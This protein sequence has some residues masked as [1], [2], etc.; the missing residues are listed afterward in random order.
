M[1]CMMTKGVAIG[2]TGV[3]KTAF[4]FAL[5][6]G[7]FPENGERVLCN[8]SPS[9]ELEGNYHTVDL[10]DT[11]STEAYQR[12][13]P[14]AYQIADVI[15]VCFSVTSQESFQNVEEKWCPEI[16]QHCPNVPFILVATK[17][18]LRK[19]TKITSQ[20]S[21]EKRAIT[22]Q[23]GTELANKINAVA[24]WECSA[25]TLDNREFLYDLV[26][27]CIKHSGLPPCNI[28]K[29]RRTKCLIS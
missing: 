29:K 14:L 3:G 18:D 26:R 24:Y 25:K 15:F 1:V 27:I 22:Q 13:R 19:D 17:I 16:A 21:T 7:W 23:Q 4:L 2:D 20:L 11:L 9:F 8:Y 5:Q 28:R 10:F 12:I 6:M